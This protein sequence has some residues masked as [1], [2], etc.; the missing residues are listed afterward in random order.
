MLGSKK[1]ISRCGLI[2]AHARCYDGDMRGVLTYQC[3][4]ASLQLAPWSRLVS[5][6][7]LS[8]LVR[9]QLTNEQKWCKSLV[10][11]KL[12]LSITLIFHW[13]IIIWNEVIELSAFELFLFLM[14][15]DELVGIQTIWWVDYQL[16]VGF[17]TGSW[18][19]NLDVW[20]SNHNHQSARPRNS[21]IKP[22]WIG[23]EAQFVGCVHCQELVRASH[24]V[25][26]SNA[27]SELRKYSG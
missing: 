9:H 23:E 16:A 2:P 19:S 7:H 27:N 18:K 4:L 15:R 14:H 6:R 17:L 1:E 22:L 20:V 21:H 12:S 26:C 5:S 25:K 24:L 10:L 13:L 8:C 11:T 3:C